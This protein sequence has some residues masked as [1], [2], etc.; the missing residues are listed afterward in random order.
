MV[1]KCEHPG[2]SKTAT[3]QGVPTGTEVWY[4]DA[5]TLK[6]KYALARD[7]GLRGVGMW[8]ACAL[9][10]TGK[11][12]NETKAMWAAIQNWKNPNA[13]AAEV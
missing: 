12:A 1:I 13:T 10:Y 4:D 7:N 3:C 8:R 9:D 2:T 11:H 5:T 6:P